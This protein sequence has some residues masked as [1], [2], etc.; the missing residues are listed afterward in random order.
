MQ[1]GGY[2]SIFKYDTGIGID[3]DILVG[4]GWCVR[5]ALAVRG[6]KA[7]ELSVTSYTL[8]ALFGNKQQTLA[9]VERDKVIN[10]LKSVLTAGRPVLQR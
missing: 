9:V 6:W 1:G 4:R 2:T 3:R 7:S 8:L 5:D 10:K